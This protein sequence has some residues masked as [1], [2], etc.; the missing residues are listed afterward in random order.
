MGVDSRFL[1]LGEGIAEGHRLLCSVLFCRHSSAV[2]VADSP[3][4]I[5]APKATERQRLQT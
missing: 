5:S 1:S 4:T 3:V 2:A